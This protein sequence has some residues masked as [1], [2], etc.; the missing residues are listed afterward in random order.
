MSDIAVE[1]VN[2]DGVSVQRQES[3]I[4]E[5][6]PTS[7]NTASNG[8]SSKPK[9]LGGYDFYKSIGSPKFVVA[10][11]VDQSELAWRLLSRAP[12]P[13]DIAG[14]IETVTTPQGKS[15]IRHPGGAHICYTPMIHAKGFLEAKGEMGR[16]GDGQFCLTLDEEGGEGPVAGID[17]GDRP[18]IVQFCANDPEILLAAAK[19]LEHRCD[20]V[21]INFGCPQGIAKRGR[22]GSFLQ[23][24]WDLIHKLI[25]TL[26]QNL[27]IP[28]TA[29]F[30]IFPDIEKTIRYAQMM[31]AAGA[32][33][34]TCHG[35]T[36]EMK[37]QMTGYADWEAIRAVK[38]AVKVPVFANGNILYREDVD[39][40]LEFTGCDG[41]MTAEGNLANPAIFVPADHPHAHPPVTLLAHRYLDIVESLK[42]PTSGSAIK[43]HLFRLLKPVLDTDEELRVRI[44]TCRWTEGMSGF[45]EIIDDIAARCQPLKEELGEGWRP[46][47]IDPKTGYRALPVFVAQPQIRAKPV[48]TEIGGHED[49]VSR[50]ASPRPEGNDGRIFDTPNIATA[51][52]SS[53]PGTILVSRHE[54]HAGVPGSVPCVQGCGGIAASR[55]PTR[56]CITHCRI[57]RAVESGYTKEEAEQMGKSGKLVGM[58]CEAH[59]DKER[60]RKERDQRKRKGREM[61]KEQNKER[62]IEKKKQTHKTR[63]A[64]AQEAR[65]KEKLKI[66]DE[67]SEFALG[68]S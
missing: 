17:C 24:E 21:D 15:L 48:S 41:V 58:G 47:A 3:S 4:H 23:D 42:T 27:S 11:M 29:K 6:V 44:A 43:S 51:P 18:L 67:E 35:R 20:A 36:R 13:P 28:V 10:P 60:A 68:Q 49:M 55:C 37:G 45:R 59:E 1:V 50:P 14:P 61:A 8:E 46:P 33:I 9:K 54:R 57:L 5:A 40:C 62:R 38:Q 12:L 63:Q 52:A 22:Y 39:R 34:L 32:Q 26:H 7:S 56:A 31:E 65:E 25:S 64:A 66:T 19:K 16:N 30:R 2:K 53:I